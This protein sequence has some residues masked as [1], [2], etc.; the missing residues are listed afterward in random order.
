[1]LTS[2]G[3]EEVKIKIKLRFHGNNQNSSDFKSNHSKA[4]K[5]VKR[6]EEPA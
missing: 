3:I 1:M 5:D 2:L 4:N 6:R